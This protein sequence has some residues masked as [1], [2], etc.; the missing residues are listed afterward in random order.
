MIRNKLEFELHCVSRRFFLICLPC[1][2]NRKDVVGVG[3]IFKGLVLLDKFCLMVGLSAPNSELFEKFLRYSH[4]NSFYYP[5]PEG[6]TISRIQTFFDRWN[7]VR[8]NP[9]VLFFHSN[10]CG[11]SGGDINSFIWLPTQQSVFEYYPE[12]TQA[13][14]LTGGAYNKT[15][16]E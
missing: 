7:D 8:E 16:D 15:A 4:P 1:L 6:V 5:I 11:H 3:N 9:V 2:H 14:N 12:S 13:F 10:I